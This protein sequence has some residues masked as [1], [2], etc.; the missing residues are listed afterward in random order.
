MAISGAIRAGGAFVELMLEQNALLRG[1]AGVKARLTSWSASLGRIGAGAYGGALPGP[2]AAIAHFAASPAGM[3]AGFLLAAKQMA[4]LGDELVHLSEKAG[5]SVEAMSALKYAAER[6]D[7]GTEQLAGGIRKMQVAINAG[8]RGQKQM[9]EV[10]QQLGL[11]ASTLSG[12]LP[13]EQIK[14][15]ADRISAIPN[16][17]ARAA[18]AV[19]IFGRAGS[20]LLPLLMQGSAGISA[21][22]DRAKE[23]GLVMS[24]ETAESASVQR[25]L[26]RHA[27]GYGGKRPCDRRGLAPRHAAAC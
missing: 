16:P 24:G 12:M 1:L 15:L 7:I 18:A 20:E 27:K 10:F 26:G 4:H 22:E 2:L 9:V 13:E 21:W 17:A 14:V 23:L 25:A 19:K 8:A 5:T 11:S 6:V 3:F